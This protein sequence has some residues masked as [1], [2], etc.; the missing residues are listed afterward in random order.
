MKKEC[1]NKFDFYFQEII[2]L[3]ESLFKV[4]ADKLKNLSVEIEI[5]LK[6]IKTYKEIAVKKKLY[7]ESEMQDD[8]KEESKI[9][10]EE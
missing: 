2:I 8:A 6:V 9:V 4:L 5:L 1:S 7:K 3:N 10:E